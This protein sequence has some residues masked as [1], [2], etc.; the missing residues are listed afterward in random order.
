[1]RPLAL[2]EGAPESRLASEVL[3]PAN[4]R[5]L[6]A[7]LAAAVSLCGMAA[8]SSPIPAGANVAG[9]QGNP[10]TSI[11]NIAGEPGDRNRAK[12]GYRASDNAMRFVDT[13]SDG[14]GDPLNFNFN[15]AG[16]AA[17]WVTVSL[18]LGDRND[19]A[20]LDAADPALGASGYKPVPAS[21]DVLL[22]GGAGRD[23]LRGHAGFDHLE[24]NIG[25]DKLF[26]GKGHDLL[27]GGPGS[28]LLKAADSRSDLV[29]CG[30]GRDK[31]TADRADA[32]RRC[33]RVRRG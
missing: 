12:V 13:G 29:D 18:L 2:P 8:I 28:D 11:A 10:L 22:T 3:R 5:R 23:T 21:V 20:R 9:C 14:I 4:R 7:G 30:P 15:C 24:G 25:A 1:M 32:V 6:V 31:A 19:S 17:P 33:E 27:Q 26:A 16:F